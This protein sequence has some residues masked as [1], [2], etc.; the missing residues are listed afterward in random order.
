MGLDYQ[1]WKIQHT[2]F[3]SEEE[4]HEILEHYNDYLV[5]VEELT[6]EESFFFAKQD[7]ITPDLCTQ[8][9]YKLKSKYH[10]PPEDNQNNNGYAISNGYDVITPGTF[11]KKLRRFVHN[12]KALRTSYYQTSKGNTYAILLSPHIPINT[13]SFHLLDNISPNQLHSKLTDIMSAERHCHI[14]LNEMFMPR[15]SLYKITN[16]EY[17]VII[18][19]PQIIA[20]KWD[21]IYFLNTLLHADD[22]QEVTKKSSVPTTNIVGINTKADRSVLI[23]TWKKYLNNLSPKPSLPGL[24]EPLVPQSEPMSYRMIFS[25]DKTQKLRNLISSNDRALWAALLQTVW[26]ITLKTFKP[27]CHD[28]H[29]P[30]LIPSRGTTISNFNSSLLNNA[31]PVRVNINT[32]ENL[33][34]I[35]KK[36]FSHLLSVQPLGRPTREELISITGDETHYN[37]LISFQGFWTDSVPFNEITNT[38]VNLVDA[39]AADLSKDFAVYF[40]YIH[41]HIEIDAIYNEKAIAKSNVSLIMERFNAILNIMHAYWYKEAKHMLAALNTHEETINL[42]REQ[43]LVLGNILKKFSLFKDIPAIVINR[44]A[45][46]CRIY[47]L[48]EGEIVQNIHIKQNNI[49]FVIS[50]KV[51]RYRETTDGWLNP[52]NLVKSTGIVNEFSLIY[53]QT[54]IFA[55]VSSEKALLLSVPIDKLKELMETNGQFGLA[56]SN[57]LLAELDKYQKRWMTV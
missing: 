34:D 17:A 57:Y 52:L 20:N 8:T 39:A 1:N 37:H 4:C 12:N 46:S 49:I 9:L 47:E 28:L 23:D 55:E 24:H 11:Q 45:A 51:I 13:L 21:P 25:E 19:Q 14:N 18:T 30:V 42:N 27:N 7:T 43:T 32:E 16:Q 2:G 40:R 50:G 35:V 33:C 29:F 22:I 10:Y 15:I 41:G 56:F 6:S 38:G 26:A 31:Y 53:D 5:D 36:Q 48:E 3:I 44:L 54:N